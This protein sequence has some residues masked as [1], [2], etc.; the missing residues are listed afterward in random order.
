M[1]LK[2]ERIKE[3]DAVTKHIGKLGHGEN[4]LNMIGSIA[5]VIVSEP[6]T[7]CVL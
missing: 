7:A 3:I 2:S 5:W 4:T 1:Q 6:Y